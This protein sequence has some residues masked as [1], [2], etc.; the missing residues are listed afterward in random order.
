VGELRDNTKIKNRSDLTD[1]AERLH[2]GWLRLGGDVTQYGPRA[3]DAVIDLHRRNHSAGIHSKGTLMASLTTTS[4]VVADIRRAPATEPLLSWDPQEFQE[5][6]HRRPFVIGHHLCDHPLFQLDRL[7]ELARSLPEHHI[8]Y[9]AGTLPVNQDQSRTP[10][11]GLSAEE[12]IQRIRECKSWMA[13]KWV[14]TDPSYRELLEQ[15]LS[16]VRPFSEPICPGMRQPQAFIFVTSPHSVTPYHIDPEHNFLLQVHGSKIVRLFDGRD[17]RILTPEELE[18]FYAKRQRNMTLKEENRDRCWTYD[19]QP[20]QGLHFPVTYPHWVQNGPEVS[21]SFSITF[22]TPDLDRRKAVY[23]V[24]RTL[25]EWGCRPTQYGLAPQLDELKYQSM[26]A[27]GRMT[28]L[29]R[30]GD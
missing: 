17:P 13:I 1:D 27:W 29:F 14:E 12:T 15:C 10:R 28:G 23:T 20:G 26:R 2:G 18:L 5:C 30:R 8:E 3:A 24:N 9:N 25:R 16:E 19:L 6:F 11:N 22:R 21:V 4:Q 7:L